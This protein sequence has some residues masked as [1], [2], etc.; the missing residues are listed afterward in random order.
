MIIVSGACKFGVTATG[1]A[2]RPAGRDRNR[3]CSEMGVP[4]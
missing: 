3:L 4:N 1:Q 2:C